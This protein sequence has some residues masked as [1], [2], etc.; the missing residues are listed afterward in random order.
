[1]KPGEDPVTGIPQFGEGGRL[2][3]DQRFYLEE[4]KLANRNRGMPLEGLRYDVTPTGMHYLL[5]H[6]DIPALD[7]EAWR[8]EI[9]GRVARPGLLTLADI[10]DLPAVT[11]TVTMECA[12]NGRALLNPRYLSQPWFAEAIGTAQ[13]TGVPL[14]SVLDRAG[15]DDSACEVLFT[16][17]DRGMQGGVLHDYQRSLTL[18]DALRDEVLLVYAMN[19]RPL[20]PQ[21]GYPLRLLVPSWYGMTSVKW[22]ARI[23]AIAKPFHGYQMDHAYRV[24]QS[25]DEPGDPVTRIRVRALMVP[26]GV[27]DWMTRIRLLTAG[28]VVIEGR[29]WAGEHRVDCVE[30]STDDGHTWE[31]AKVEPAPEPFCWQ[32]WS[33]PWAA[34]PGR[35]RLRVRATDSAGNR[36]PDESDWNYEGMANNECQAVEVIVT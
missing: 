12:G 18:T 23:E 9:G 6:F 4:V 2:V 10:R 29:A 15:I 22:L 32:S 34:V 24:R 28:H 20:E 17:C 5:V 30:L 8:L 31:R 14:H 19:G 1:M 27:P 7:A 13:W 33:W 21:H 16:G 11:R 3:E 25:P 26:P 36:Q 35:Y